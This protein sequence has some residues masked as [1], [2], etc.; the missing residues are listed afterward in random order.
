MCVCVKLSIPRDIE[1]GN[2]IFYKVLKMVVHQLLLLISIIH[3]LLSIFKYVR[4]PSNMLSVPSER[5]RLR[6]ASYHINNT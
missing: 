2:F 1:N 5:L 4:F 6:T 3:L